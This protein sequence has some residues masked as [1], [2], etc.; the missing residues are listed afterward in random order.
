MAALV[1][2]KDEQA[3]K[4]FFSEE[5]KQK[6]FASGIGQRVR[7][8]EFGR[9]PKRKRSRFFF[10]KRTSCLP[11]PRPGQPQGKEAKTLLW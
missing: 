7:V 1:G 8:G 3:R 6:T 9:F 11:F 5:K 10:Q 2:R 4:D